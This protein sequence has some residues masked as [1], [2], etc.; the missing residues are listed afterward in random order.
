MAHPP[1]FR[2]TKTYAPDPLRGGPGGPECSKSTYIQRVL[3]ALPAYRFWI[4]LRDSITIDL[5]FLLVPNPECHDS[6]EAISGPTKLGHIWK[7]EKAYPSLRLVT[8]MGQSC[9]NR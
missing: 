3:T 6:I 5:Y 1:R 8:F 2:I 7:F 4:F 9:L